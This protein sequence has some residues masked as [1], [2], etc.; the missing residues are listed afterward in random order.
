NILGTLLLLTL[1][2]IVT[3]VIFLLLFYSSRALGST[4]SGI[5]VFLFY[6]FLIYSLLPLSNIVFVRIRERLNIWQALVKCYKIGYGNWWRTFIGL[7]VTLMIV[8]TMMM[9][10]IFPVYFAMVL[11][12]VHDLTRTKTPEMP[13][14]PAMSAF[15]AIYTFGSFFLLTMQHIFIGFNYFSLSEKYDSYGLREKIAQIG[16]REQVSY[17]KQEGE[18]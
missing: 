14:G 9:I 16:E 5:L 3:V 7:F 17:S 18:F 6:I 8:Y 11:A 13:T 12:M 4:F 1:L 15:W 2:V 10:L